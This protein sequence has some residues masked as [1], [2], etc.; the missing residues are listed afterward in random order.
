MLLKTGK[1]FSPFHDFPVGSNTGTFDKIENG[2]NLGEW[3]NLSAMLSLSKRK[4]LAVSCFSTYP[5]SSIH[6][7]LFKAPKHTM[8]KIMENKEMGKEGERG[9]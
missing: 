6:P 8:V 9:G 1:N 3:L 2:A 4:P 5:L 7:T